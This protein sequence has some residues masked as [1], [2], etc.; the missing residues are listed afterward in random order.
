[1]TGGEAVAGAVTFEGWV[2]HQGESQRQDER[3]TH[4]HTE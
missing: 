1:M 3:R 2:S 4:T